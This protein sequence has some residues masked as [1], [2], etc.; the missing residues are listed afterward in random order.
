M[1]IKKFKTNITW[2]KRHFQ[3]ES[4]TYIVLPPKNYAYFANDDKEEQYLASLDGLI[5][6]YNADP[7]FRKSVEDAVAQESFANDLAKILA[8]DV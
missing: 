8:G 4:Y 5:N 1:T 7:D 2:P 6:S 3:H